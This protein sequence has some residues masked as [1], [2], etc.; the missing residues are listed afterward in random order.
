MEHLTSEQQAALA[1]E[2]Q[3]R[4]LAYVRNL[5]ARLTAMPAGGMCNYTVKVSDAPLMPPRSM[6]S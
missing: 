3:R 4:S 2:M 5:A 1:Q 6:T